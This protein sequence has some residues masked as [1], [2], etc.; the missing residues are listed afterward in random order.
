[1]SHFEGSVVAPRNHVRWMIRRDMFDIMGIEAQLAH[2]WTDEQFLEQLR[3]RNIIGSVVERGDRII[4]YFIYQLEKTSL[5]IIR[6][7]VDPQFRRQGVFS[8]MVEKLK[9]KLSDH[10]RHCIEV[11]V[12]QYSLD[13]QLALKANG[14]L[15][16]FKDSE[17]Y[18]FFYY[19]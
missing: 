1:M 10:R 7:A 19:L 14:F 11:D 13:L 2:S 12:D 6:C 8:C 18:S 4:G 9:G 17:T 3:Q 16:V 5:Q 15:G